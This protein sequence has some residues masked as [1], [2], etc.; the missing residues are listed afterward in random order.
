MREGEPNFEV[1]KATYAFFDGEPGEGNTPKYVYEN[2][3]FDEAMELYR[4]EGVEIKN[5]V[6][7]EAD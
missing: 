1:Q 5:L 6:I 7:A 3:T 2:V 4:A